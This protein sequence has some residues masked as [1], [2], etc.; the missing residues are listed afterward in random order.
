MEGID[1]GRENIGAAEKAEQLRILLDLLR[2]GEKEIAEGKG[3]D[4]EDVLLVADLPQSL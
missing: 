2:R 3:Y 1:K 4:L